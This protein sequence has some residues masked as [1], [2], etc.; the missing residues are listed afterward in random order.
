MSQADMEAMDDLKCTPLH[1]AA[2]KG[3]TEALVLLL[4]NGSNIYAQDER[5]WTALHYA[6]YNG[7]A[8]IVNFLLKWEADGDALQ[9]MRTSQNKLAFNMSKDTATKK[10]FTRKFLLVLTN[11]MF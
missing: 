11:F 5:S 9:E 3:S 1:M 6:A 7:H 10:A 2:K 4:Q 8:A